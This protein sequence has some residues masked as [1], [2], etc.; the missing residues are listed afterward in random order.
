MKAPT[1]LF[2]TK[3]WVCYQKTNHSVICESVRPGEKCRT[4]HK[5]DISNQCFLR[6]PPLIYGR[7]IGNRSRQ[8][9]RITKWGGRLPSRQEN[10]WI[11]STSITVE[12]GSYFRAPLD[13]QMYKLPIVSCA[14]LRD[15]LPSFMSDLLFLYTSISHFVLG[16]NCFSSA[17]VL[18]V[19]RIY[20][21]L[22]VGNRQCQ[23]TRTPGEKMWWSELLRHPSWSNFGGDWGVFS[24]V[25]RWKLPNFQVITGANLVLS[26]N[27]R[28][29]VLFSAQSSS[30]KDLNSQSLNH[31]WWV[32]SAL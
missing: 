2:Y 25:K 24:E 31:T 11:F 29:I 20:G 28:N 4:T 30:V 12:N 26:V 6:L 7:L 27:A 3:R 1:F 8:T 18:S 21:D 17:I 22:E 9:A 13:L 23:P 14:N 16:T 5:L 15:P 10:C 32:L 19:S